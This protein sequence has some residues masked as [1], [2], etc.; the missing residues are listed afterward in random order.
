MLFVESLETVY[1]I[2]KRLVPSCA[3]N[4]CNLSV[5]GKYACTG[6]Y[7]DSFCYLQAFEL[8]G[9]T[10]PSIGPGQYSGSFVLPRISIPVTPGSKRTNGASYI[11]TRIKSCIYR[12]KL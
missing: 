9:K 2:H 3:F 7:P 4:L 12:T 1:A 10:S 5:M 11:F 8:G 6:R